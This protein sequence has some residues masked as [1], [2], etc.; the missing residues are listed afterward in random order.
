MGR[1]RASTSAEGSILDPRALEIFLSVCHLGSVTAAATSLGLTQPAVSHALRRLETMLGAK[2]ID[3]HMRP[4]RMTPAGALLEQQGREF[5]AGARRLTA[6]VRDTARARLPAVRAG[7]L[8]SFAA[9]AGP[10]LIR[11]LGAHAEHLRVWSGIASSIASDFLSRKVDFLVSSDPLDDEPGID[12]H[13]LMREPLLLIVPKRLALAHPKLRVEVVAS[14][15]PLIRFSLR[16]RIGSEAERYLQ[17]LHIRPRKGLEFD[18]TESVFAM[19]A[20]GLGWAIATPLCL[21]QG[22]TYGD[23]LSVLPLAPSPPSRSLYLLARAG[24]LPKI[25]QIATEVSRKTLA[26]MMQSELPWVPPTL[27]RDIIVGSDPA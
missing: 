26:R 17:R 5:L 25:A 19:V 3:R 15:L 1:P 2:L 20:A 18:G 22:R 8:D 10:N 9:T 13:F 27:K 4:L 6:A 23:Q 14:L 21:R 11:A 7:L 24:E 12:R 16:S